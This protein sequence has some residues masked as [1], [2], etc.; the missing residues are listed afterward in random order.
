M[1]KKLLPLVLLFIGAGAGIGAGMFLRPEPELPLT[2]DAE[3][4]EKVEVAQAEEDNLGAREYVKMSNQ[5]VVPVIKDDRVKALVVMSLSVE[6]PEGQKDA[7]YSMEPKLRDS[8]LQVLFDH[9]N[10]GGFDGAF[11]E[12]NNLAVLRGALREI[13]QRDMGDQ[14]SDVLIV[15]IARQD[16]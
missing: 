7:I 2:E 5:F 12:A 8:F 15:E 11:T 4:A 16:Y 1:M 3:D 10:I 14:I 9:A 6:V 13:A